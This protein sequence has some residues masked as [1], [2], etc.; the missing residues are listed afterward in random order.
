MSSAEKKQPCRVCSSIRIFLLCVFGLV[1]IGIIDKDIVSGVAKLSPMTIAIILVSIFGLL[2]LV[3]AVI[4]FRQLK[5]KF[6]SDVDVNYA[7]KDISNQGILSI[8]L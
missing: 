1:I 5:K 6:L 2:A 4:E 3:K 8:V 7:G